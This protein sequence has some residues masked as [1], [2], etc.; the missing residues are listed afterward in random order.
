[1]GRPDSGVEPLRIAGAVAVT[2][3]RLESASPGNWNRER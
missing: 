1:M 2:L 3:E